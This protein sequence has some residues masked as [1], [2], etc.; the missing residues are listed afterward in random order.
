MNK[1]NISIISFLSILLLD[2]IYIGFV[3]QNMF[4]IM[5]KTIQGSVIKP[6]YLAIFITYIFIF[7]SYFYF[8]ILKRGSVQDAFILGITTYAIYE[9]TNYSI[10]NKWNPTIVII[11]TLWG[12]ILFSLTRFIT[13]SFY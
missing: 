10:F 5:I 13:K 3:S 8:I 9:F 11:D 1:L 7:M 4:N 2:F 12:G 6:R